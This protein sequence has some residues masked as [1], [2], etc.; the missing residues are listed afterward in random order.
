MTHRTSDRAAT[1]LSFTSSSANS[2]RDALA[3]KSSAGKSEVDA[4]PEAWLTR[5]ADLKKQGRLAEF[6]DG[7]AEFRKRYPGY[8][9]PP[10]LTAPE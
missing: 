4:S 1:S 10:A 5:L 7:L 9:V 3:E 8:A 6:R 2:S